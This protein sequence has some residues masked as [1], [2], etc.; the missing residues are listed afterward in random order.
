VPARAGQRLHRAWATPLHP[1]WKR[2]LARLPAIAAAGCAAATQPTTTPAGASKVAVPASEAAAKDHA[3]FP[4]LPSNLDLDSVEVGTWAEYQQVFGAMTSTRRI[5]VVARTPFGTTIE[6]T[7]SGGNAF[8][9]D[10]IVAAETIAGA[11]QGGRVIG[12]RVLQV[13]DSAPSVTHATG[14]PAVPRPKLDPHALVGDEHVTV[15]A[16]AFETRHYRYRDRWGRKTEAWMCA[17]AAPLGLVKM[18]VEHQ[19][20]EL[21]KIELVARGSNATSRTTKQAPP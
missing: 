13:N 6:T 11:N 17:A 9:K 1:D 10:I 12:D 20:N 2:R 16:G 18:I 4:D 7:L 19:P 14:Q 3:P 8:G 5:A 15:A 21:F